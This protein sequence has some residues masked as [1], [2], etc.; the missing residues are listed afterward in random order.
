MTKAPS[1]CSDGAFSMVNL[2]RRDRSPVPR[3]TRLSPHRTRRRLPARDPRR[4]PG[5][6]APS[7]PENLARS[8]SRSAPA[9]HGPD[10]CLSS[11]IV[12][13]KRSGPRNGRGPPS[14][15][16]VP[17][18][19]GV[20]TLTCC[21]AIG[22]HIRKPAAESRLLH[23]DT[24]PKQPPCQFVTLLPSSRRRYWET[25]NSPRSRC[26]SPDSATS[27]RRG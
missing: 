3:A 21:A 5:T 19:A 27:A 6:S 18:P 20:N 8:R 12:V 23:F 11:Y 1:E 4:T 14:T 17:V 7:H 24:R 10:G 26:S 15:R 25:P 22:S 13:P 2:A 9:P 16:A